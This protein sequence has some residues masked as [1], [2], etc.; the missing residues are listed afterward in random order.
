VTRVQSADLR[1]ILTPRSVV[2]VGARD[3]SPSSFGVVEALG[4]VG[5]AG[6]IFAV[7]RSATPAHGLPT[8]TTCAAIGEPVDAAVL[9]VPAGAVFDVLDDVA[10]AGIGTAVVFSSGWGE[11]G[12]D[13]AAEQRALATRA[14]QLGVMLVGPNCLGFMNVAARAGAW[15]ASVPPNITPGPVA[16][17]SQSGGM[18]NALADLAAEYGIGLSHI[19]TTGN[20]A[21]L[22]TT[23][24]VEYLVEDELTRSVAIFTEAIAEPARF[25]AA[26]A[27]ARELGKAIVILKAG[28][29][30][31]AARNAVSHTGSLVGDDRVVDAALRQ[32]G[33]IRVRSLEEL[34][35]TAAVIAHAG[36]LRTPGV[37]VVSMSGGS[38]DVIADEAARLGLEL[39]QFDDSS[40]REIRAVLPDY[41]A[42]RNPLDLTGGSLGN[43]LERVL[44]IVDRQDDFGVVAVLCNVPAYDSCKTATINSLIN[45]VGAGLESITMP[46]FVL[47][48]SV[49][50]LNEA[51]RAS[52][53]AAGVVGLPGLA[54]GIAALASLS[55][56]SARRP[57]PR[58]GATPATSG[59]GARQR[60]ALSEWSARQLLEPLGVPF[61]PAVLAGSADDAAA[62][63]GGYD[64][65][66]AVKLVSPDVQ[67]KSDVGGIRLGVEGAAN[68]RRAFE[69]VIAS[70]VAR[71]GGPRVEGVQISPMRRGG[72][73]LLVGVMRDPQWGL[74]LAVGLG[75]VFVEALADVALRLLPVSAADVGEMLGELRGAKVLHGA[76][77]EPAVDRAALVDAIRAIADAAWQLGHELACIEVN[78]LRAD[79]HGAEALDALVVFREVPS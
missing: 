23:D 62:A 58:P 54:L 29:S 55:K 52:T 28:S 47:S 44:K 41:A 73:E 68:V 27:R 1:R 8:V 66:V 46:G 38:V 5:F 12:P 49:A 69:D 15:I 19:V 76:R 42:V 10:A 60:G 64:G 14:R 18:G 67:H 37:A 74:V 51:G 25:M 79:H 71:A 9:L 65:P 4:R 34:V 7:N 53:A 2:I 36:M 48:Q 45:T 40:V 31:I 26:A 20:E 63:A 33:A 16:I 6:R 39:P 57:A 78:P 13:G 50:H 21:M 3:S 59:Q 75:G 56:W 70:A 24:V 43:E 35:V 77:G 61:V 32:A 30:E 17:V 72:V 11:A 22:S